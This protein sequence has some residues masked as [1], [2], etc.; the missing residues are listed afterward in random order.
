MIPRHQS[1]STSTTEL[2]RAA[3]PCRGTVFETTRSI[4]PNASIL[5]ERRSDDRGKWLVPR[6]LSGVGREPRL[7]SS[8]GIE[9]GDGELRSQR[10][11]S[12]SIECISR[13]PVIAGYPL[14]SISGSANHTASVGKKEIVRFSPIGLRRLERTKFARGSRSATSQRKHADN[15][16][17]K[18]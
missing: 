15:R 14:S 5:A 13:P 18:R 16:N 2:F 7:I 6:H 4:R 1:I 12:F 3:S 11:F 10:L 8:C 9:Y 17:P